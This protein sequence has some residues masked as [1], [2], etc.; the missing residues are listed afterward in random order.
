MKSIEELK[1]IFL[2]ERIT[3]WKYQPQ[4]DLSK[5]VLAELQMIQ[6]IVGKSALENTSRE[7][8]GEKRDGK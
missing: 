6:I 1:K 3:F 2:Q 4:N 8:Q 7:A 5:K